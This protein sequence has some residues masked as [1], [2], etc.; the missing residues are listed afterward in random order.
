MRLSLLMLLVI[1]LLALLSA[2]TKSNAPPSRYPAIGH[3]ESFHASF[4]DV[5]ATDA[6]IE[7]LTEGFTWSE[8]PTWV[9]Q[10]GYLLFTDVPENKLYRWS[11]DSGLSVFLS[12]SGYAGTDVAA[13]REAGANGL[14]AEPGGTVLLADSGTRIVARLD[15]ATR[16]KTPLATSF[17]GK[18][19]NSPN[20]VVRRED[21]V[22]FFTDPPYGLKGMNDSPVKELRF[23]GVYRLNTD[24]S[25]HLLDDSL[26]F[27]NGIAL[28]PDQRT[29][30]VA[31]SDPA[32]PI[33]MAYALDAQGAV[34]GK[35][36]FADAT[37]LVNKD[38]PGLPDGMA[39][40][41]EG[42]LFATGPGGVIVFDPDGRRLG[43]IET[44]AAIS[45]CAFGNDG[46]TL[47]MTSHA[48]L[49]RVQVTSLGLEFAR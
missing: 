33:W 46:H 11:D 49:A 48:L 3:L 39:V 31:N 18:R 7:K 24:G 20:D 1:P 34:T 23:N 6:R 19:F 27:P 14:F 17:D 30:Y 21:G 9:R 22:V 2:C 26:S 44:G 29:L 15:P 42:R 10:G 5:V 8:G 32:R 13:L 43:R 47:Y 41:A 45:N 35:R 28:S 37:D 25:V 16:T 38:T 36:V 12:P 40:S 4:S